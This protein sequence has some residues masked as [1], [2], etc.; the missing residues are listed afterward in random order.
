MGRDKSPSHHIARRLSSERMRRNS[1]HRLGKMGT[2]RYRVQQA[3]LVQNDNSDIFVT[4]VVVVLDSCA[5]DRMFATFTTKMFV[6]A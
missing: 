1:M 2:A 6:G 5:S 4:E 3:V